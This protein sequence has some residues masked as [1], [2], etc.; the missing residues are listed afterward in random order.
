MSL[1]SRVYLPEPVNLNHSLARGLVGWWMVL[2]GLDGGPMWYDLMG[3][4]HGTLT[5]MGSGQGWTGTTRAEG[6]GAMYYSGST[7]YVAV[8]SSPS[9]AFTSATQPRTYSCWVNINAYGVFPMFIS[10]GSTGDELRLNFNS[11]QP[12]YLYNGGS[13][14]T[15]PTAIP[16]NT[17]ALVTGTYDGTTASIYIN[18]V[19]QASVT[20]TSAS[21]TSRIAFGQRLNAT[22]ADPYTGWQDDVRIYN[23]ALTAVE[24]YDLY[25]NSR[26]GYPR[27]LNQTKRIA[28]LLPSV[29][30]EVMSGEILA[31]SAAMIQTIHNS[32]I[33][34]AGILD[35]GSAS[36]GAVFSQ[37]PAQAGVWMTGTTTSTAS[38]NLNLATTGLLAAGSATYSEVE[39]QTIIT[40]GDW[41][42]GS[43]TDTMIANQ[44]VSSAGVDVSGSAPNT[45]IFGQQG[46]GGIL[47]A[48]I[49]AIVDDYL[50]PTTSGAMGSGTAATKFVFS[51]SPNSGSSC[52]GSADQSIDY[53]NQTRLTYHRFSIDDVVFVQSFTQLRYIRDQVM[54][55][56]Y[57]NTFVYYYL[58]SGRY[59]AEQYLL[60]IE[61]YRAQLNGTAAWIQRRA[62]RKLSHLQSLPVTQP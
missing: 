16:L 2:P 57:F 8:P 7:G 15:S 60:S 14:I 6:Q 41:A 11:G 61:E 34:S 18:G 56:Y 50:V 24:V 1:P 45:V 22:G 31:G 55:I 3:L 5:N 39:N 49:A 19:S 54:A 13:A 46:T 25:V 59:V 58:K 38:Y 17:W 43:A 20:G 21:V 33:V 26:L 35:A 9:L 44:I 53:T 10:R 28:G 23:R 32:S 4:N 29:Y 40:A 42:A 36:Y 37:S 52:G 48:G 51:P 47:A 27:L 62:A 30:N 12:E